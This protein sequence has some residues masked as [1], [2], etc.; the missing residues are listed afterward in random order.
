[1]VILVKQI[2]DMIKREMTFTEARLN[3]AGELF[4]GASAFHWFLKL[5]IFFFLPETAI[6]YS[7]QLG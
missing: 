1:V 5:M 4:L 2:E 7:Q 3:T 6:S